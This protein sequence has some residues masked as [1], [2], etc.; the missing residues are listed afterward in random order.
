MRSLLEYLIP[1]DN[2]ETLKDKLDLIIAEANSTRGLCV[3]SDVM[4]SIG[5]KN[6]VLIVVKFI[7]EIAVILAGVMFGFVVFG[8]LFSRNS[9]I[10]NIGVIGYSL[11]LIYYGFCW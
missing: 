6:Y 1:N 8:G 7:C 5:Y 4:Q 10:S 11:Y 2:I 3:D 9:K